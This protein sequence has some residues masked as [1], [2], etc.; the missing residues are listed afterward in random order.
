MICEWAIESAIQ[1]AGSVLLLVLVRLADVIHNSNRDLS[2]RSI[3]GS[4]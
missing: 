2:G 1:C 3:L 4:N